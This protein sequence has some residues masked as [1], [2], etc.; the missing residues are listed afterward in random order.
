MK[1]RRIVALPAAVVLAL[2]LAGTA[3]ADSGSP[4]SITTDINGLEVT[5][6]GTWTWDAQACN[7]D[8]QQIVGWAVA[9]G[10][11]GYT[12]NPVPK[13]GGGSYFMGDADQG[14]TVVTAGDPCTSFPGDWGD[15]SHT[16]AAPGQ[17]DICVIIY[18]LR[19]PGARDRRS[20]RARG[21]CRPQHRELGRVELHPGRLDL[22][23]DLGH[24]RP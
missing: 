23:G 11:P 15:L 22:Q 7:N 21:R 14:N 18:D 19:D 24:G 2:W 5:V 10:E 8:S 6:S 20:Q 16:Y 3:V 4:T 9:W 12:A 13:V 17:Y 1:L